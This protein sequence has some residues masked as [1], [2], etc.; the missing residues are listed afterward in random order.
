MAPITGE[1]RLHPLDLGIILLYIGGLLYLGLRA[2]HS[3]S[4][5]AESYLL[6]GRRLT[7]IPFVATLVSTWYGGILGVGEFTYLR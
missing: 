7:L 3:R 4:I 6:G 2:R 1:A 5:R